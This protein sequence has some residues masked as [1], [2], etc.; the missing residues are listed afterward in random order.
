MRIPFATWRPV[1]YA[2]AAG[3]F[4]ATPLGWVLHVVVGNGSPFGTF[5]NAQSPNRRF[6]HLWV[7]KTGAVEQFA[8]TATKSW[9]QSAGN[10]LY[11]SVETEGFP[12][13]PLT[14]AQVESLARIHNLLG[15]AD[16]VVDQVGGRGIGTHVMGGAAWGNHSCPGPGPRAGQRPQ[17]IARARALRGGNGGPV[18]SPIPV[19][20]TKPSPVKAVVVKAV[21]KVTRAPLAVDG[22][23]GP[24]TIRQWQKVMGT[25][26]DGLISK[27][28]NLIRAVQ[29][30]CGVPVDGYLGPQTWRG[31]Q[32]RLGVTA[33][34]IP[35]PVTIKALQKR[36]NAGQF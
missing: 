18:A 23:M 14:D 8:D 19:V 27:P 9:A 1:S 15:A 5:Q 13:E 28:S 4:T 25:V 22:V 33:D 17:I 7:A 31:I 30:R 12:S 11:W 10:G 36:L 2:P 20:F 34:G 16:V 26:Q 29:K 21:Q 6:S 32:R 24:A 3:P 35:G